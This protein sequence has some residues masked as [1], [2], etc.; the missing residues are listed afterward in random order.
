MRDFG[1][2]SVFNEAHIMP[3]F[4]SHSLS[5][6]YV[7]LPSFSVDVQ[8]AAAQCPVETIWTHT[9]RVLAAKINRAAVSASLP[10]TEVSPT[11]SDVDERDTTLYAMARSG[12]CVCVHFTLQ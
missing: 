7:Y 5:A 1:W 12:V 8:C 9:H 11:T 4:H 3:N 10:I 6:I 2:L